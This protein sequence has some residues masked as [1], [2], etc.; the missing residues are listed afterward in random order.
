MA[1]RNYVFGDVPVLRH[2]RSQFPLDH[3]VKTSGSV[4]RLYPFDV[5]EV[6]PGDTFKVKTSVVT[7]LSTNF[8]RPVMDN[9]FLDVYYFYVPS[10]LLFDKFV[11]IFGEN[12]ESEWANT[13][14]YECPVFSGTV[15]E[16][17]VGDYMGLP[18]K[19]PLENINVLPFR[20]FAKIY[21]EWFRDQ[22]NIKPMHIQTGYLATSETPSDKPWA[23]NNYMGQ[24][25]YVSKLH[26][27]FT[28]ALP[29]PQKGDPVS[30]GASVIPAT[31]LP[32]TGT[33]NVSTVNS[34]SSPHGGYS[35]LKPRFFIGNNQSPVS[36]YYQ[37]GTSPGG[38]LGYSSGGSGFN[39]GIIFPVESELVN[40]T[41]SFPETP[42]GSVT[43]NDLR[44]AFQTQKMLERDARGGTRFVEYIRSAFGVSAGDYRLQRSEFLGGR[45]SPISVQQVTQ[46][47]GEGSSS[48][49]LGSVGAYSLS[50]SK[51]GYTKSFLEPGYV[52]GVYCIRQ[53]HTYQQGVEKFWTRKS[54]LDF[55]N[56]V[57]SHIGEQPVMAR[58]LFAEAP[59]SQI[60][61]YQEAWADLR[62]RPARVSGQMRSNAT[63]TFDMW[64]FADVYLNTP[65]LSPDFINE[66]PVYVDRTIGAPSTEVDQFLIDF[67]IKNTA[68]RVL[69]TYSEP[70]LIDHN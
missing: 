12:T 70:S 64:H 27:Y 56:P 49:P 38:Y 61:G 57:F 19:V 6:Y 52:I 10:R 24:C 4:G 43:V 14:E 29:A 8:I 58:E 11:N 65:V 31:S 26:D 20:A 68:F 3:S 41:A 30:I 35:E 21:N 25:P 47:T 40:A 44:L 34:R 54:R 32:V 33:V 7:R 36:S 39:E 46:T 2:S 23:P 55:Y 50:N 59:K 45:R 15:P 17:S 22:N 51:N 1:K 16:K 66:T 13:I 67:Y 42:V 69:P 60:F 48:S 18:T 37:L 5:Q 62:N 63:D 28:S 53:F 9:L